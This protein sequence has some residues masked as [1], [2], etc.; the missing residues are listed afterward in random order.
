M[1]KSQITSSRNFGAVT[2]AILAAF[3]MSGCSSNDPPLPPLYKAC[4]AGDTAAV[5]KLLAEGAD[6][7]TRAS[8]HEAEPA[9]V[10][11]AKNGHIKVVELLL[12]RGADV[13]AAG[14]KS[15]WNALMSAACSD[16]LNRITRYPMVIMLL[17]AGA[18]VRSRDN[19]GRTPL[20]FACSASPPMDPKVI[21]SLL[22]YGADLNA[23]DKYGE[24]PLGSALSPGRTDR[25][26]QIIKLLIELGA[27]DREAVIEP[28]ETLEPYDPDFTDR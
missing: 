22:K 13:N 6:P 23:E 19:S 20:H 14:K 4:Q 8:N 10:R 5:E 28:P 24:T 9:I 17:Q 15:R 3:V 11:A 7:N 27:K 12:K 2:G 21:T 25:D 18:D 1:A 16:H 26:L